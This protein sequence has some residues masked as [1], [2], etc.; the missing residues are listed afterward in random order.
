MQFSE[1]IEMRH[2]NR[3]QTTINV[4]NSE[5]QKVSLS[6][7][8]NWDPTSE[9]YLSECFRVLNP[10]PIITATLE[11]KEADNAKG[12]RRVEWVGNIILSQNSFSGVC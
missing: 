7:M 1:H 11:L 5:S 10:K 12:E 6:N 2:F 9:Q 3:V 8:V 4:F